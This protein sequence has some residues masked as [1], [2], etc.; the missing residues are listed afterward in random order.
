MKLAGC[1]HGTPQGS[2]D[3]EQPSKSRRN[4]P[5]T[6][7]KYEWRILVGCH[8]KLA[9]DPREPKAFGILRSSSIRHT[10]KSYKILKDLC[11]DMPISGF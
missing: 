9:A 6:V 3:H 4:M 8:Q 1:Q 7:G 5:N 11:L 10:S 2:K